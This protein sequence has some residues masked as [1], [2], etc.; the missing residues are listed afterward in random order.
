MN[1]TITLI[2]NI[3]SI[4][5]TKEHINTILYD[6]AKIQINSTK[7]LKKLVEMGK[8]VLVFL[9]DPDIN[10]ASQIYDE[11]QDDSFCSMYAGDK[12]LSIGGEFGSILTNAGQNIAL[13]KNYHTMIIDGKIK[14]KNM[15]N[16]ISNSE[17]DFNQNIIIHK[18]KSNYPLDNVNNKYMLYVIQPNGNDFTTKKEFLKAIQNI[19]KHTIEL[20]QNTEET[21]FTTYNKFSND[22]DILRIGLYGTNYD[23]LDV[24]KK[25]IAIEIIKGI[26]IA[27]DEFKKNDDYVYLT[28]IEF[29][30]DEN[31]FFEAYSEIEKDIFKQFEKKKKSDEQP[32]KINY[33][34]YR[35]YIR[36]KT[37][38]IEPNEELIEIADDNYCLYGSLAKI[39]YNNN[40]MKTT[41]RVQREIIKYMIKM[42]FGDQY[43]NRYDE[44]HDDFINGT[45]IPPLLEN[46]I[47]GSDMDEFWNTDMNINSSLI[48]I[49]APLL[50]TKDI[51][52]N[53]K[54]AHTISD[55][56]FGI[57]EIDENP[58]WGD[59]TIIPTFA[60]ELYEITICMNVF[61]NEAGVFSFDEC[62]ID[63]LSLIMHDTDTKPRKI[64]H[65]ASKKGPIYS[66]SHFDAIVDKNH[67]QLD[68][69][70]IVK[71]KLG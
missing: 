33:D 28:F 41:Q 7:K 24:N 4:Y 25:E 26:S 20:I 8:Y 55:F 1:N 37:K 12:E 39:V 18:F 13:Y 23:R 52:L 15:P 2:N 50:A 32:T 30:Y 69:E 10:N 42:S 56:M 40:D 11:N 5:N 59:T 67:E 38:I 68:R 63:R 60:S 70:A 49:G 65:Y 3:N 6:I 29:E 45:N 27:L 62:D 64:V 54:V 58:H 22:I 19:S 35:N 61:V 16:F 14:Q 71:S 48:A 66:G 36:T 17:T 44:L 53:I 21:D 46:E 47:K 43:A 9:A 57:P 31:V 34:D 51:P